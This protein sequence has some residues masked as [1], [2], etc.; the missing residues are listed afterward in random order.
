MRGWGARILSDLSRIRVRKARFD[1]R[2]RGGRQAP[3]RFERFE[4]QQ[5]G[6]LFAIGMRHGIHLLIGTLHGG[7]LKTLSLPRY[8][9]SALSTL[10]KTVKV[11]SL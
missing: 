10:T 11:D 5:T 8:R 4:T 3:P 2:T 7:R 9:N 6:I 1:E